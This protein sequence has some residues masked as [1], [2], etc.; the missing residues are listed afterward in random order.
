[1][2]FVTAH[3]VRVILAAG[4]SLLCL[5]AEAS[6][7]EEKLFLAKLLKHI[8]AHVCTEPM[9]AFKRDFQER[10][11]EPTRVDIRSVS[12]K[13]INESTGRMLVRAQARFHFDG[14]RYATHDIG[15]EI[16]PRDGMFDAKGPW[17]FYGDMDY[18]F[19]AGS[20]LGPKGGMDCGWTTGFRST[21]YKIPPLE[22]SVGYKE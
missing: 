5:P 12:S 6:S 13:W 22:F 3:P 19:T 1:M 21:H 11:V 8:G 4:L 2:T 7:V 18:D 17:I 9:S 15:V 16:Q 20:N 14:G 10:L